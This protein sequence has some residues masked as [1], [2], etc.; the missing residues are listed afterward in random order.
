MAQ[1]SVFDPGALLR[2]VTDYS[3]AQ[4]V[5]VAGFHAHFEKL[6]HLETRVRSHV[7]DAVNLRRIGG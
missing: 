6:P 1:E 3:S 5:R 2:A 4:I 7:H